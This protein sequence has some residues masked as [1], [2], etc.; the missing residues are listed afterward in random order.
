MNS[1]ERESQREKCNREELTERMARAIPEDGWATPLP[2]LVLIRKS[3]ATP[4]THGM[5]RP[6][7]CAIAQGAKEI[8]LGERR[9]NYDPYSYLLPTLA[10][11]T[12]GRVVEASPERPY[13]GLLL[14]LDSAVVGSVMLE[15][16]QPTPRGQGD[17]G[18]MAV[19]PLDASLLDA[20]LRLVRLLDSPDEAKMLLPLVAREIVFRLLSGEQGD[21]LRQMTIAGGHAHRIAQAVEKLRREIDQPL[22]V[23]ELARHIGMSVSGFHHHFKAVTAMSP[24]QF[25]KQLRL[26]EA[27]RLLMGERLDAATAGA[28][29]GYEDAS[30]F[31]RDYKRLF[32]ATPMR[33]VERLREEAQASA[34]V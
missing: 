20:T 31:S 17:A 24:L 8:F 22:R 23:S 21:R 1:N 29:V 26:R 30:Y 7:F 15:M 5:V 27:R 13:L 14:H 3:S 19:S 11:P 6:S 25:Q 32:G 28:R 16:G 4:A 34:G 33:D 10:A 9:Y 18:A 12:V 2:G